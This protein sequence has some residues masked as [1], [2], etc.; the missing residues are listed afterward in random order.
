MR[1]RYIFTL[2][3]TLLLGVHTT[4]GQNTL[5][6]PDL[7]V[8]LEQPAALSVEL[9]NKDEVVA[10]QFT[11][12]V[13]EGISLDVSTAKMSDR[14]NGHNV[15]MRKTGDNAY[16]AMV[17]S[18][19]N[20]SIKG[21]S[22]QLMTLGFTA[23][24][25]LKPGDNA[26]LALTNTIITGKDS[27]NIAT[28]ATAGTITISRIPDLTVKGITCDKQ[29]INPGE[30]VKVSWQVENIGQ[31]ATASGWSEQVSLVSEDGSQ[32][33]IIATTRY[34]AVIA[35]G[36]TVN[37]Q[38]EITLPQLLGID[39]NTQL[40][41]RVV[42][43]SEAGEPSTAQANNTVF[44]DKTIWLNKLTYCELTPQ[45]IE[46]NGGTNVALKVSRS[47]S[48]ANAETFTVSATA[49]SRVSFPETITIPANQSA[50]VVNVRVTDNTELDDNST[51]TVTVNGNGYPEATG[52]FDIIDNE[53]PSLTAT[54]WNDKGKEVSEVQEGGSAARP[55]K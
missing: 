26:S 48:W 4:F 33:K 5:T 51:I 18:G 55:E 54:A 46:E 7:T 45:R 14:S 10:L 22:G 12:T 19:Q 28:G 52:S 40:Q 49:D 2:L 30:Q 16:T 47:G 42:P 13:P 3:A 41:V 1:T 38:T 15:T 25:P 44:G 21:H 50:V 29:T 17:T 9:D 37:R 34:D 27:R 6:I 35:V 36:A 39:G 11:L 53:V 23:L 20:N 24:S 32:R 31:L 43:D 8:M